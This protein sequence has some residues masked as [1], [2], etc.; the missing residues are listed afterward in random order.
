MFNK[1]GLILFVLLTIFFTALSAVSISS[2]NLSGISI[3]TEE[4][5]PY[6]Y[7]KDGVVRGISTDILV[8]M[9]ERAG[10][11]K[12]RGDIQV[13]PWARA[14]KMLQEQP[15]TLLY[16]TARTAERESLFRWVGPIFENRG[17]LYALK[18]KNLKIRSLLDVKKYKI[19]TIRDDASE[20][21]LV[22]KTGLSVSDFERVPHRAANLKKLHS[23]RIEL[24]ASNEISFAFTCREAGLDPDDFVPVIMYDTMGM[25]YA[26]HKDTPD[27]VIILFQKIFDEIKREGVVTKIF[28]EYG[29][30][31]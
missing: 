16:T 25:Y 13:L 14:Y 10:S 1:G 29:R 9:L 8:L 18:K 4:W 21:L 27:D 11:G 24:A 15:W 23:G 30:R 28:R 5:E 17:Y 31:Q 22:K 20:E 12:G 19:G 26:F 2:P 3:L 7:R 6:N